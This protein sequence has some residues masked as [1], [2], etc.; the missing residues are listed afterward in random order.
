VF[1]VLKGF[2]FAIPE[3]AYAASA[4]GGVISAKTP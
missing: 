4:T 2:D 3:A 1:P